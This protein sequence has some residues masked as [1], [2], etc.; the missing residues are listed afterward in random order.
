[1]PATG[2][3]VARILDGCKKPVGLKTLGN[4]NYFGKEVGGVAK[5]PTNHPPSPGYAPGGYMPDQQFMKFYF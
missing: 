3:G 1:M 5:S 2:V 4:G